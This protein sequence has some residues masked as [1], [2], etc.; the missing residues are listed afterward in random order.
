MLLL[1][2]VVCKVDVET[3]VVVIIEMLVAVT[4]TRTVVEGICRQEQA[5]LRRN[6]GVPELKQAGG[7]TVA[8]AR[9]TR[10]SVDVK[11][12]DV[13]VEAVVV[14]VVVVCVEK[15]DVVR[16]SVEEVTVL[17]TVAVAVIVSVRVPMLR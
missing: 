4:V 11:M 8:A 5:E 7:L 2:T 6:A 1:V 10:A 16:V 14:V 9:F 15:V 13:A 3:A 17:V 12:V